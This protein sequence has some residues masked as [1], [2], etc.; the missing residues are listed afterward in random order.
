MGSAGVYQLSKRG[1]SVLGIDQFSPPHGKGSSHGDTRIIRQAIGEGAEYVPL[2]LRAYEIWKEIEK[3]A[4]VN[5]LTITGGLVVGKEGS[6]PIHGKQNFLETTLA[7]AKKFNIPHETLSAADIKK[8]FPQFNIRPD[9]KG[10][11]EY[12]AGFLRPELCVE[13]QLELARK[14]GVELRLNEKAIAFASNQDGVV[15]TTS[16][17]KYLAQKLIVSAGPWVGEVFPEYKDIFKVYRQVLYW[18]DVDGAV[19]P[20]LP[21][22]MPVF[23]FDFGDGRDIYGFPAIDGPRGG[24]KVAFEDYEVTTKPEAIERGVSRE[25]TQ[26]AYDIYVKQYLPGLSDRCVKT[27]TCMYTVTPDSGFVIDTY[28]KNPNIIIASPCSGHGFKH[29]A[30]IGEVLADMAEGKTPRV[31]L[32]EFSINRFLKNRI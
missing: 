4:D 3:E 12:G 11:F 1:R 31:D 5:F 19:D 28:L 9:D 30:A 26:Q 24:V 7:T 8:K 23:I 14:Y 10:Y 32:G 15:V 17:G 29:S 16:E 13:T 6:A 21:T 20:Y 25:E 22:N 27:A 18:F 2:V